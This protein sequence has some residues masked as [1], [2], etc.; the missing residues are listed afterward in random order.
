MSKYNFHVSIPTHTFKEY[1]RFLLDRDSDVL[2]NTTDTVAMYRLQGR[3]SLLR[4]LL[5]LPE[6][7]TMI[8]DQKEQE[9]RDAAAT[10]N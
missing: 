4:E 8:E 3:R 5:N 7:L 6:A 9:E 1:V 10:R 2:D